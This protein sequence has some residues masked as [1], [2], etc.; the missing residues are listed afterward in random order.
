[1]H[2]ALSLRGVLGG[3][4]G[5]G[6]GPGTGRGSGRQDQCKLREHYERSAAANAMTKRTFPYRE[7]LLGLD[8]IQ[9]LPQELLTFIRRAGPEW[10]LGITLVRQVPDFTAVENYKPLC[11][12]PWSQVWL[13]GV[14]DAANFT[15][16]YAQCVK[17]FGVLPLI[18]RED[19]TEYA[20]MVWIGTAVTEGGTTD[21]FRIMFAPEPAEDAKTKEPVAAATP[22]PSSPSGPTTPVTSPTQERTPQA[23]EGFTSADSQSLQRHADASPVNDDDTPQSVSEAAATPSRVEQVFNAPAPVDAVEPQAV[24]A[25]SK[26]MEQDHHAVRAEENDAQEEAMFAGNYDEMVESVADVPQAD[27]PQADG[28]V[29][30]TVDEETGDWR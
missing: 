9:D 6:Q 7:L 16:A 26:A 11:S 24:P 18:V 13:P 28:D 1:M 10:N 30:I 5:Q 19:K 23:L 25:E 15:A 17:A 12:I 8:D 3:P 14:V 21:T 20:S 4:R 27:V 29:H 22:P 2:E